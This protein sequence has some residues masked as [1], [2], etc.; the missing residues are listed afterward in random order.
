MSEKCEK[1]EKE[2]TR[3]FI[4]YEDDRKLCEACAVAEYKKKHPLTWDMTI[5]GASVISID[6]P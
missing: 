6:G 2:V 5:A 3:W 4:S 1:C